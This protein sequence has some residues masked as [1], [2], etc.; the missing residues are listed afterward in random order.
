MSLQESM[1]PNRPMHAVKEI[2]KWSKAKEDPRQS[3]NISSNSSE[4]RIDASHELVKK[5]DK[6]S[7]CC[8]H[9]TGEL[10][11]PICSCKRNGVL[12]KQRDTLTNVFIDRR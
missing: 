10:L 11:P 12:I 8:S 3:K 5:T 4:F 1:L 6:L 2:E 7:K 9:H